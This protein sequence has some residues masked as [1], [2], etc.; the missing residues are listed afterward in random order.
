M[1]LHFCLQ[2]SVS[3]F[4]LL[5]R[6]IVGELKLP[7]HFVGGEGGGGVPSGLLLGCAEWLSPPSSGW[8]RGMRSG[9][10]PGPSREATDITP[11]D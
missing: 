9:L 7:N 11:Y 3:N 5:R 2:S 4:W 8:K 6:F 10:G 1:N